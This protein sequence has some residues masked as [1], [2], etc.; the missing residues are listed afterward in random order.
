MNSHQYIV[1][2]I[3]LSWLLNCSYG[4]HNSTD[5]VKTD[6]NLDQV[7]NL[8]INICQNN[9]D[10]PDYSWGCYYD[11][12]LYIGFCNINM[13]CNEANGCI[14]LKETYKSSDDL[15]NMI[16][17]S[18]PS[19]KDDD[20]ESY[21]ECENDS[22]CFAGTCVN[23]V[24]VVDA[25]HKCNSNDD[26][27]SGVCNNGYCIINPD[28]PIMN[29]RPV[30]NDDHKSMHVICG[31]DTNQSC[32]KSEDCISGHCNKENLCSSWEDSFEIKLEKYYHLIFIFGFILFMSFLFTSIFIYIKNKDTI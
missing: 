32:N 24:C 14:A 23:K 5:Y 10:C 18:Y 21:H 25:N 31:K 11:H 6:F 2:F 15:S 22:D 19:D 16:F 8:S 26:C 7:K 28:D 20:L 1:L 17:Q 9:S 3:T 4:Y 13:F 30:F 29:C 12:E 27:F